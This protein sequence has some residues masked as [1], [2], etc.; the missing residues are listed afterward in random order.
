MDKSTKTPPGVC[1]KHRGSEGSDEGVPQQ[2]VHND[3]DD[4][5][6][7]EEENGEK[8]K[9]LGQAVPLGGHVGGHAG[10]P[11]IDFP[12]AGIVLLPAYADHQKDGD[13]RKHENPDMPP[14]R[15][16]VYGKGR[17]YPIVNPEPN[18]APLAPG[19]KVLH[20]LFHGSI[21]SYAVCGVTVI[22]F[23]AKL[24]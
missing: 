7:E 3:I 19:P 10:V 23:V 24:L 1:R 12:A 9:G 2:N 8:G 5:R 6:E 22:V 11:Q 14:L 16:A 20:P 13:Q 15:K 18:D 17:K 4:R 21:S